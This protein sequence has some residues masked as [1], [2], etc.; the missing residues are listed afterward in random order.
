MSKHLKRKLINLI[1]NKGPVGSG[2]SSVLMTV[3]SE[4]PVY[5]GGIKVRG[6]VAYA[7]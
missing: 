3:L 4:I 2:K 5:K 1:I 6:R 7:R